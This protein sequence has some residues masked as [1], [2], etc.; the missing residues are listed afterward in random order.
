MMYEGAI[1]WVPL[2][3]YGLQTGTQYWVHKLSKST[4]LLD[5]TR[6]WSSMNI[7]AKLKCFLEFYEYICRKLKILFDIYFV[8]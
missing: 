3:E 5:Y 1:D 6:K 8:G 2:T 7:F 4:I